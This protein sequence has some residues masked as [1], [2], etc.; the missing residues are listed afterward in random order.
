MDRMRFIG[1]KVQGKT[2]KILKNL[3][4]GIENVLEKEQR[5]VRDSEFLS[6]L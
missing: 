4:S 5:T 3:A 6:P 2:V 1:K